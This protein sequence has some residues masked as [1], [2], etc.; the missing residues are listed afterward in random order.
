[1]DRAS[2]LMIMI[3]FHLDR[4]D[5]NITIGKS[6]NFHSYIDSI[7]FPLVYLYCIRNHNKIIKEK[8]VQDL[9]QSKS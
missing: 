4:R 9:L 1:M 5:N 6:I 7:L 2:N 3:I 8:Y